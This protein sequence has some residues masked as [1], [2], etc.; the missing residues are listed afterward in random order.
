VV[1]VLE[2]A[3]WCVNAEIWS[4]PMRRFPPQP[5][6]MR[7]G[8]PSLAMTKSGLSEQTDELV[9][10]LVRCDEGLDGYVRGCAR[11]QN[12]IVLDS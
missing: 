1:R 3:Q 4:L 12:T 2:H 6:T 11:V 10:E 9:G 5:A 7:H 8:P